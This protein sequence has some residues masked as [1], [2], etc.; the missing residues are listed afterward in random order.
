MGDSTYPKDAT[1][2]GAARGTCATSSGVPKDVESQQANA[3]VIFS[4]IKY[5][6]IG[7]TTDGPSPTPSPSGGC[8]SWDGKYCGDT[9]E[10][11]AATEKQCIECDGKWCTDC[12]PPFTTTTTA[13]SPTPTPS[14]TPSDCPG[15][16][17]DAC[18]DLCPPAAFAACV[19]SC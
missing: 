5:G 17:L 9:T 12:L 14:P 13:P 1:T 10:Y 2:P 18:I 6:P 19:E 7:S 4:D 11:C 15:G 8:C 3:K 16:S